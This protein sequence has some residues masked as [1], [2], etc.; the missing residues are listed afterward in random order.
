MD[1]IKVRRGSR[2]ERRRREARKIKAMPDTSPPRPLPQVNLPLRVVDLPPRRPTGFHLRPDAEARAKI[3]E[4]LDLSALRKLDFAGEVIPEGR[5]DWRLE[6]RLGATVVQPCVLTAEPVTTRIETEVTRR[7]LHDLA[8]PAEPEAEMPED[9]ETERLGTVIDPGTVM[10]EALAL[11]LPDYPRLPGAELPQ[12]EFAPPGAAPLDE[13]RPNP[14]AVLAK[15]K[16]DPD[17]EG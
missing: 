6:A 10:R 4:E 11:A 9:D 8:D 2:K 17:D 13:S 16:S 7:F 3:A 15:L 12:A 1:Y 5:R 14:F